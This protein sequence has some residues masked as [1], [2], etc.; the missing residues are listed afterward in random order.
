MDPLVT[1]RLIDYKKAE[2]NDEDLDHICG[3]VSR[4]LEMKW[5]LNKTREIIFK[6]LPQWMNILSLRIEQ[7][8]V[9]D[10]DGKQYKNSNTDLCLGTT[11]FI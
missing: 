11:A 7:A 4:S 1:L 8:L 9:V 3:D 6:K 5:R 10:F 2:E